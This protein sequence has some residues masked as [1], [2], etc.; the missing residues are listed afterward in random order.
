MIFRDRATGALKTAI[1]LKASRPDVSFPKGW[2]PALSEF[3][4]VDPVAQDKM[5][6]YDINTQYVQQGELYHDGMWRLNWKVLYYDDVIINNRNAAKVK[7]KVQ[8]DIADL[9]K[10]VTPRRMR[11]SVLTEEGKQWLIDI[12][13]KIAELRSKL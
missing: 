11:E 13:T 3:F 12:E 2:N 9:E 1:E 7:A 6:T 5:P 10:L 8:N 4:G